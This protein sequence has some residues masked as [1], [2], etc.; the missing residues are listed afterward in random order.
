[1]C[2]KNSLVSWAISSSVLVLMGVSTLRVDVSF[3]KS[4]ELINSETSRGLRPTWRRKVYQ[5]ASIIGKERRYLWFLPLEGTPNSSSFWMVPWVANHFV[6][7]NLHLVSSSAWSPIL[8]RHVG[9]LI[10]SYKKWPFGSHLRTNWTA[11][12]LLLEE[13]LVCD[14]SL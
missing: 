13:I 2:L 3:L 5:L 8:G 12:F 6:L 4:T 10:S 1:M 9:R 7:C 11:W 14:V